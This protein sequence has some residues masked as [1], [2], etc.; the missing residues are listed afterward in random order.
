MSGRVLEFGPG[1]GTNFKCYQNYTA[2]TAQLSKIEKYVAVEPNSYFEE[3]MRKEKEL[4]GLDFPLEFV[5]LKGEEIDIAFEEYDGLFDVVILTHVLCS[6]DSV[7]NVL[8]N[9]ERALKPGVGRIIFMEHVIAKEGT[10]A[11]YFQWVAAP[12]L[13][14]VGNG[15]QF[16][17]L[18]NDIENY[19]GDQFDTRVLDFQAPLPAFMSFARPHIRGVAIKK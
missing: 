4:R 8:S 13:N 2:D 16:R 10:L 14:I 5:G 12:V 19:L 6:V 3:E 11:W 9:A 17:N 15:C 7:K 18:R 1:P